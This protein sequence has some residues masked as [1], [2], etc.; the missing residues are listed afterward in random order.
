M[1]KHEERMVRVAEWV[2][3]WNEADPD[4]DDA[5]FMLCAEAMRDA[6]FHFRWLVLLRVV[7]DHGEIGERH[8]WTG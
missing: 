3:R 5:R 2:S 8:T 6:D 1:I 4:D 7:P